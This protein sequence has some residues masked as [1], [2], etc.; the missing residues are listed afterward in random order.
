ML[1][2][3]A[4]GVNLLFSFL[5]NGAPHSLSIK[6]AAGTRIRAAFTG[7]YCKVLTYRRT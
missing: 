4:K 3:Y 7:M 1:A 5:A 2:N 6:K